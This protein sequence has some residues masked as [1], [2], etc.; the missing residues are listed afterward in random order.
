M[1]SLLPSAA[2]EVTAVLAR[3]FQDNPEGR[4]V[5]QIDGVRHAAALLDK[6]GIEYEYYGASG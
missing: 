3:V 6:D 5:Q 2:E 1:V 4:S